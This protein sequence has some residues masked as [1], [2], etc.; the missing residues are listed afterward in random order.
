[1]LSPHPT[2]PWMTMIATLFIEG[3]MDEWIKGENENQ[4][5]MVKG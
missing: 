4:G 1:M 5:N 3:V 2:K